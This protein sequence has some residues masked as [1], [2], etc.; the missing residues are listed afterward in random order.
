MGT[1]RPQRHT[2]QYVTSWP[3]DSAVDPQ[4]F[5]EWYIGYTQEPAACNTL[6]IRTTLSDPWPQSIHSLTM[7]PTSWITLPIRDHRLLVRGGP[8]TCWATDYLPWS[9]A[10]VKCCRLCVKSRSK[11][12]WCWQ[13]WWRCAALAKCEL[14]WSNWLKV[15]HCMWYC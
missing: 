13:G 1:K 15:R 12:G 7:P 11:N 6:S 3:A 9:C 5:N 10:R 8:V 14:K 2:Y 4:A